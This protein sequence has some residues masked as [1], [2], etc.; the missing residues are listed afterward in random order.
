MIPDVDQREQFDLVSLR[1][2]DQLIFFPIIAHF[3][4]NLVKGQIQDFFR[5]HHQL[6]A[7][8]T[9]LILVHHLAKL[10]FLPGK[11]LPRSFRPFPEAL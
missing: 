9:L 3:K 4:G 8:R 5:P 11:I 2:E 10:R 7:P 1:G 6:L